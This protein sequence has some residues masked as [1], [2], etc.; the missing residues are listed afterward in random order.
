MSFRTLDQ[1]TGQN[2]GAVKLL[3]NPG[4]AR[5]IHVTV[6]NPTANT[7][8]VFFGNSRRELT[9]DPIFGISGFAVVAI[10]NNEV[11]ATVIAVAYSSFIL[12]G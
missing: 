4:R 12:Q 2:G 9:D 7:H 5:N 6:T 10:A 11:T 8:I 3:E 1:A